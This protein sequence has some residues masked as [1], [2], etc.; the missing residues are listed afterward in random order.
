MLQALKLERAVAQFVLL[1]ARPLVLG[2]VV[3][4][5]CELL[6]NL[7]E[8]LPFLMGIVGCGELVVG[9]LKLAL[10]FGPL[11][12]EP[13]GLTFGVLQAGVLGLDWA[14]LRE[15]L[16]QGIVFGAAVPQ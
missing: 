12:F 2:P 13:V 15:L 7:A 3:A 11:A 10:D 6:L 8:L 4:E 16:A 5:V 1:P 9:P 14:Q